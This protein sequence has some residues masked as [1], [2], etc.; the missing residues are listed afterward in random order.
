VAQ[1]AENGNYPRWAEV[2]QPEQI[3]SKDLA[4]NS[5]FLVKKGRTPT[6]FV[7]DK[8]LRYLD[9]KMFLP[10]PDKLH[11]NPADVT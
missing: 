1:P 8:S 6:N 5:H 9:L 10:F 7:P 11:F 4:A 3:L 2:R